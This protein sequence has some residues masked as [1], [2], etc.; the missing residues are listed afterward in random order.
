MKRWQLYAIYNHMFK[1]KFSL[2]DE[3]DLTRKLSMYL[4]A[5]LSLPEALRILEDENS[6]KTK[7]KTFTGWR[8]EIEAGKNLV[9]AFDRQD[10]LQ[11]SEITKTSVRLGENSASLPTS[12]NTA[13]IQIERVSVLKK[14][15][16][17]AMAYPTL[18][19]IGTFGLILG[20][21][22]FVFPKIT[23]LFMSLKVP[24][25]FSTRILIFFTDIILRYWLSIILASFFVFGALLLGLKFIKMFHVL[26]NFILIRLPFAGKIIRKKTLVQIFNSL[27]VL[28]N[29][30]ES[31][32]Q[33]L[34]QISKTM[35]QAE[36]KK[37]LTNA[38]TAVKEGRS[39]GLFLKEN[40]IL[41]PIF[42]SGLI[43]AG[44]KTGNI[45]TSLNH[46]VEILQTELDEHLKIFAAALEPILMVCMSLLIGFI[47]LSIILP[48]YGI[49]SHFQ[50]I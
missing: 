33:S 20:L 2:R 25:P 27:L 7:R 23:P 48:I 32:D 13:S 43:T 24:L 16:I 1:T 42:I 26:V 5:S 34:I 4:S 49:T 38:S 14:K 41:Y 15:I 46:V 11:V 44:E 8:T 47:A 50:S 18:I 10:L 12:L 9:T 37:S 21:L 3:I 6:D 45:V 36:Y 28:V 19:M 35:A 31:L 17:S 22:L 40:R 29:G 30:N 39:F